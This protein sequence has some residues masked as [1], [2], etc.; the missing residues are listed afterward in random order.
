[1]KK[2]N[3]KK[4]DIANSNLYYL[5]KPEAKGLNLEEDRR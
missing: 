5:P 4:S 3:K 2:I 1:M